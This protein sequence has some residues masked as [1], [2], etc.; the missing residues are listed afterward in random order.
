MAETAL[1]SSFDTFVFDLDGTLL[2][3]L[4]DLVV[5]TNDVLEEAGL[6]PRTRQQINSYVGNGALALIRQAVPERTPDEVTDR[7]HRRWMEAYDTYPNDLTHPYEGV[8]A[9]LAALREHGCK[10]GILSNK[11]DGG[12]QFIVKK[13][14][15][16]TV[17]AVHGEGGPLNF[18]RKPDPAGL[19]ATIEE[20]GSTPERTVYVGDSP[21]DIHVARNAGCYAVG[22]SWGYHDPADFAAE[23]WE[24]DM[25][26]TDPAQI[27]ALVQE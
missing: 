2:D 11:F 14:L 4:D 10:L 16:G 20:L 27:T 15:D 24:P 9:M 3:T 1:Q 8:R 23:G 22:V 6:P 21:G 7:V 25:L 18:P 17:D 19:L 13:C 5:L 12:V 26:A